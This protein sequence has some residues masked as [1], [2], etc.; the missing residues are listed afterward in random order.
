MHQSW[1]TGA[2]RNDFM[3]EDNGISVSSIVL[4]INYKQLEFYGKQGGKEMF[5]LTMHT[6]HF[7]CGYITMEI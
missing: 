3:R 1:S 2:C 5:Y 4:L 7:I 6:I